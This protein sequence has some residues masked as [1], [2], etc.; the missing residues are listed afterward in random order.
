MDFILLD[1]AA[2]GKHVSTKTDLHPSQLHGTTTT[3]LLSIPSELYK[4]YLT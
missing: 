4:S 3:T 1:K 2:I